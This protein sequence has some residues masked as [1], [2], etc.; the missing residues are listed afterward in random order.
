MIPVSVFCHR[1]WRSGGVGGFSK[2]KDPPDGLLISPGDESGQRFEGR[3][4][5]LGATDHF[6]HLILGPRVTAALAAAGPGQ[7]VVN[8]GAGN[9]QMPGGSLTAG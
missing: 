6:R 2:V 7:V 4:P 9:A 3:Q 1:R 5:R 8:A